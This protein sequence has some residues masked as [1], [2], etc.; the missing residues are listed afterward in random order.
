MAL[1]SFSVI[2]PKRRNTWVTTI[3]DTE[4]WFEV[5]DVEAGEVKEVRSNVAIV[6]ELRVCCDKEG[7]NV[8]GLELPPPPL[9]PPPPPCNAVLGAAAEDAKLDVAKGVLVRDRGEASN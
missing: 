8:A 6:G 3:F 9:L 7:E 5:E 2:E 1:P 4:V